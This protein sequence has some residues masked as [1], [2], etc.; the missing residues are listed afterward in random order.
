[1]VDLDLSLPQGCPRRGEGLLR[2]VGRK[3]LPLVLHPDARR[4]WKVVSPSGAEIAMPPPDRRTLERADVQIGQVERVMDFET[5]FPW[6]HARAD[7]GWEPDPWIWDDQGV[8]CHAKGWASS[9]CRATA[10]R[11]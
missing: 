10:P 2:T 9:S 3:G 6:Q 8:V 11:G 1:M 4:A 5:G 7:G